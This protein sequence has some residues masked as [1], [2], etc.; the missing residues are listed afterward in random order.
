MLEFIGG[1]VLGSFGT[2]VLYKKDSTTTTV[3]AP[4]WEAPP[5]PGTTMPGGKELTPTD[6]K[7]LVETYIATLPDPAKGV[8]LS[9]IASKNVAGIEVAANAVQGVRPDLAAC[10]RSLAKA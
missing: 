8:L 6:C 5:I 1:L 9:A 3:K 2:Y 7:T 10:L 4:S